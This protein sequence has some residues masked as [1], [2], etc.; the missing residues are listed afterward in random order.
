MSPPFVISER[1]IDP[2]VDV[3]SSSIER[4]GSELRRQG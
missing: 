1:E 4:V 2:M 3:L